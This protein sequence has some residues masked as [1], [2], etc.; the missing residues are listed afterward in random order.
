MLLGNACMPFRCHAECPRRPWRLVC[1]RAH[2]Y[3]CALPP[4]Q[5]DHLDKLIAQWMPDYGK[6]FSL[7]L[8]PLNFTVVCDPE[9]S[10]EVGEG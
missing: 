5:G 6:L 7:K 4:A 8:G 9:A 2:T 3:T 10:K 1:F